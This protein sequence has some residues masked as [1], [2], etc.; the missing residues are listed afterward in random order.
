MASGKDVGNYFANALCWSIYGAVNSAINNDWGGFAAQVGC[1]VGVGNIIQGAVNGDPNQVIQGVGGT[2]L[3]GTGL[4]ET[5]V[6]THPIPEG[7]KEEYKT[8]PTEEETINEIQSNQAA[9]IA[10]ASAI[11]AAEDDVSR[12]AAYRAAMNRGSTRANAQALSGANIPEAS[13]ASALSATKNAKAS[14]QNDYLEKMG[15][16]KALQQQ[17]NNKY[18]GAQWNIFGGM[19]QGAGIGGGTGA[20]IGSSLG[21]G[22]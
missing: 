8:A 6:A 10:N 7:C 21:G 16:A 1:P 4:V 2:I 9:E 3:P 22:N 19:L 17:A 5:A 12:N 11:A 13:M 18:A 15:Y 14:T 20:S